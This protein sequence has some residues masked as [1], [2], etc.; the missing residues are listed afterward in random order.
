[1][2]TLQK[3]PERGREFRKDIEQRHLVM[4]AIGGTIGTGLFLASG[5]T[6]NQAGPL[7]AVIAYALG[8]L[9]T[10]CV[11][12]CL[13]ELAVQMPVTG[14]FSHYTTELI[15]PATGYTVAWL[16]WLSWAVAIGS[17]LLGA[18]VLLGRWFPD[19]PV[20]IWAAFFGT[21]VTANN[22]LSVRAFA[23]IEFW[24][25]L[26]KVI[27]V[28]VF[29][30]LGGLAVFGF[31]GHSNPDTTGIK[32]FTREGLFPT[33]IGSIALALL[34]VVFA[35]GGTE[36]IGIA[37]GET[38]DPQKAIPNALKA[39]VMRLVIFFVGTIV[40][41]AMFLPREQSGLSESPFVV[42]FSRIGIPYAADIMNFVIITA[43]LSAANSGL[44]AS[45]RMLWSLGDQG[46]LP[47]FFSKLTRRGTP[48]NAILFSMIGGIAALL[49]SVWAPETIYLALVS[50]AGFAVVAVWLSISCCQFLFRN[51]FIKQG[52]RLSELTYKTRWHP[53]PSILATTGC[54]AA[55]I[56]I[57]FDPEQRIALYFSI[58]FIALCYGAYYLGQIFNVTG[59]DSSTQKQKLPSPNQI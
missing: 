31:I 48:V 55:I 3:S 47:R 49:S 34:A 50:I 59:V 38:R 16:Y 13:G 40:V 9:M 57:A 8:A 42:V 33:G 54:L 19:V 44:Y 41:I 20:W 10:Y 21:L 27:T 37:A 7:G 29:I 28:I 45:A 11:M 1:M 56:G 30:V 12:S 43:L 15:G 17:E 14:S 46:Q 2:G 22:L 4:L 26:V 25:S 23:E 39:T 32:N 18:G 24:L 52:G 35:F 36:V 58:P 51:K 5:F 53:W 6:V